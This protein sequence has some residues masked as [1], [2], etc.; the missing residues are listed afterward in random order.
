LLYFHVAR[1][2]HP[3]PSQLDLGPRVLLLIAAFAAEALLASFFLDNASLD[4]KPGVLPRIIHDGGSWTVRWAIGFAALFAGFAFLKHRRALASAFLA[5][6]HA[7]LRLSLFAAHAAALALFALFSAALYSHA[8][9]GVNPDVAGACWLLSGIGAVIFLSLALLPWHFWTSLFRVTGRLWI[10]A[11]AGSFAACYLGAMSRALWEP[12]ARL[13][14]NLVYYILKPVVPDM[15]VRPA[16]LQLGTPRF[17][18]IVTPQCSGLEGAALLLAFG[19][20]WLAL[21]HEELRFPQS[22]LLLP[23]GLV[24]LY[25]LNAVRIAALVLI[26]HAGARDI[27]TGGFHSQAGWIAFSG[28]AFGLCVT[29]RHVPWFLS[30]ERAP[31]PAKELSDNPAAAYLGPFLAILAA[32]LLSRAASGTFEWLYGLRLFAAAA[33]LWR[34]RRSYRGIDWKFDWT[35]PVVGALVFVLWILPVPWFKGASGGNMPQVLAGA[36]AGVRVLWLTLRILGGVVAV[37]IAEELAFRGYLLRRLIADP[38]EKVS[39][40]QSTWLSVMLSSL[41]FG[42]LHGNHWLAGMFAGMLFAWC[43]TRRGRLGDAAVAHAVANALLAAQ[44]LVFNRWDLW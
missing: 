12:T 29:A 17:S 6:D 40:R 39:F 10:Y 32:G 14:F 35:S 21:F 37:P 8:V 33:V 2:A 9:P 11:A 42:I 5:V 19:V 28:V 25:L 30:A 4:S 13:T 26:G 1:D 16:L 43:S 3:N 31:E 23:A 24:T 41:V 38:F 34:F 44:V 36:T 7:P 27:A 15:I 18:V 20:L 22:L